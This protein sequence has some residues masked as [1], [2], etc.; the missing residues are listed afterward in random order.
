MSKSEFPPILVLG[1]ALMDCVAAE[2]GCLRPLP[3]GAALNLARV[4]ARQAHAV[5]YLN[6]LSSDIFGRR[7]R[8]LLQEDGVE[9]PGSS[10]T[11]KPTSLALVS[12]DAQ[13]VATYSFYREGVADRQVWKLDP[14]VLLGPVGVQIAATTGLA[15]APEDGPALLSWLQAQRKAGRLV[16]VDANLRPAV[17][18]DQAA[19]RSNVWMA[20]AEADIIKASDEDLRNLHLPAQT[21]HSFASELFSKTRAQLVAITLGAEGAY[22]FQR[23]KTGIGLKE[24]AAIALKDTIGAGDTFLGTLLG[25]IQT[26]ISK[27]TATNP[28]TAIDQDRLQKALHRSV[29]AAA[30]A[31]ESEGCVPP[32]ANEINAFLQDRSRAEIL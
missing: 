5:R 32:L 2:D 17:F 16:V 25:E 14:S 20:L 12:L 21:P 26:I 23:G 29:A 1:E 7:L 13:G 24:C 18:Q 8:T 10:F 22:V 28:L 27:S 15:L 4:I 31:C 3:G 6:P 19:Y 9:L 30:L 11:E